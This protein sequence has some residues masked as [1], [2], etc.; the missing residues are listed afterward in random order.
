[1]IQ[2]PKPSPSRY[3]VALFSA[4]ILLFLLSGCRVNQS[5]NGYPDGNEPAVLL[6]RLNDLPGIKAELIDHNKEFFTAAFEVQ[7]DQYIDHGNPAKGKFQQKFYLNHRDD[8]A[9]MV[10]NIN[11]YSVPNNGFVSEL[12]PWLDA[13]FIHVE[14]RYFAG[15]SPQPM[16]YNYLTIEQAAKDHHRIIEILRQIYSGKWISTGISKGG[17]AT[18]FH[19]TYFPDD[20]DVSIPY[21]APINLAVEDERLVDFLDN[22]GTPECRARILA[23]QRALLSDYERTLGLFRERA[24]QNNLSFPMGW[25]RAFELS[26]LEYEFA[27]WQWSGGANC[28][29]I[30]GPGADPEVLIDE[31]FTIDAPGF[32]TTASIDYFFPFFYQAYAELGMYGYAVDSLEGYLKEYKEYVNN[33]HTFIPENMEVIYNPQTLQDV[34]QYLLHEGNNFI[35]VYGE[36]DAWSATA[37][38]ADG[39]RTNSITLFKEDGSHFTRISD[40]SPGQKQQV[41]DRLEEWLGIQ[42]DD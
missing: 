4:L 18:A 33:Y 41:F 28:D 10:F 1:M 6:Q 14:H 27:Y 21:V 22:V 12:V 15:S 40:L 3:P 17:Q 39:A 42:I 13:N 23:F 16:D 24:Q 8:Q 2:T 32:F 26:I 20:V 5:I 29:K 11:G 36:N 31:L 35:F 30:P 37:F 25:R 38:V 7:I 34:N 19:R 9:P